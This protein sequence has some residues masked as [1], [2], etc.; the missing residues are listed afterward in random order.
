MEKNSFFIMAIVVVLIAILS[1]AYFFYSKISSRQKSEQFLSSYNKALALSRVLGK[2][3]ETIEKFKEALSL[4]PDA[5]VS[6]NIT[7]ITAL[8]LYARNRGNDRVEA[9]GLI[10]NIIK[11]SNISAPRRAAALN[12]LAM[13]L[14]SDSAIDIDEG[15]AKKYVFNDEPYAGYLSKTNEDVWRATRMI[16]EEADKLHPSR[17]S[18]TTI[19]L[20]IARDLY[21]GKTEPGLSQKDT[22]YLIQKN[23]SESDTIIDDPNFSF[24]SAEQALLMT[25]RATALGISELVLKNISQN[26]IEAAYKQAISAADS[27]TGN[28]NSQLMGMYARFN[29]A[30]HLIGSFGDSRKSEILPLLAEIISADRPQYKSFHNFLG[31]IAGYPKDNLM[32]ISTL[33][34]AVLSPDFRAFLTRYGWSF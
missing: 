28:F 33:K 34:L 18:K 14:I 1:G 15:F 21:N 23:I 13:I 10:K 4:A 3:D 19:A 29:Y 24:L 6:A 17:L 22:A 2:E 7:L 32:K 20:M 11:N 9:V 31:V 30:K 25:E 16:S 26:D 27:D 12:G 8:D 5:E